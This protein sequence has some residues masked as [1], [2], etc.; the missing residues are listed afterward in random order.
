MMPL[1]S[2]SGSELQG[3]LFSGHRNNSFKISQHCRG[4]D[5][6]SGYL[7][8]TSFSPNRRPYST[9]LQEIKEAILAGAD[10]ASVPPGTGIAAIH[11]LLRV[12]QGTSAEYDEVLR[13]FLERGADFS[14]GNVPGMTL[15]DLAYGDEF[16]AAL[17]QNG[18]RLAEP[19]ALLY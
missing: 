3:D 16:R 4:Q 13:L 5:P 12:K 1:R 2:S 9:T 6:R 18:V 19:Q 8:P 17:I 14:V 11:Q 10:V 15:F 7:I